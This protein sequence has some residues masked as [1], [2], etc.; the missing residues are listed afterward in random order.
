MALKTYRDQYRFKKQKRLVR[1][2]LLNLL[3]FGAFS[4]A[5][6]YLLFFANGF[7]VRSIAIKGNETVPAE[8]LRTTINKSLDRKIF[9]IAIRSNIFLAPLG[10]LEK[11]IAENYPKIEAPVM[12]RIFFHGLELTIKERKPTGIWCLNNQGDCFYFDQNGIAFQKAPKTSGFL[13]LTVDDFRDRTIQL[14]KTIATDDWIKAVITAR[15]TLW[16]N[17]F[18]VDKFIIPVGSFDEFQTA[19]SAGWKIFFSTKSDIK[20]QIDAAAGFIEQKL[21]PDKLSKLKYIDL[22]IDD[23]IYFK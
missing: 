19:T 14:G 7:D 23:K 16:K 8:D 21:T 5:T 13:L 3:I 17:N 9:F 20:A 18:Q 2:A 1:R 12:K 22:R 11:A 10:G 4:Y 6:I 15:D